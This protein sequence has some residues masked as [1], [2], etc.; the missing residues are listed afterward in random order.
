MTFKRIY[1]KIW[2]FVFL[3]G[4]ITSVLS[5]NAEPAAMG[6]GMPMTTGHAEAMGGALF[7]IFG[8]DVGLHDLMWFLMALAHVD[9]F[10]GRH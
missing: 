1:P 8:A 9:S 6:A 2:P 5:G 10:W 3:A 4:G 7:T